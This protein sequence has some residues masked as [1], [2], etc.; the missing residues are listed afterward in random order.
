[1]K[2]KIKIVIAD[3]NVQ[4]AKSITAYLKKQEDMQIIGLA[5][6]GEEA[7]KIIDEKDV[8]VLLLDIMMPFLD[9]VSVLEKLNNTKK[10]SK[11]ICIILSGMNQ[12]KII[13][14]VMELGAEYYIIKPCDCELLAKRI[15]EL[16]N[17]KLDRNNI[18]D[19]NKKQNKYIE[20]SNIKNNEEK[21]KIMATNIINEL[22]VPKNLK[23]YLYIKKAII[24][25]VNDR[26]L[27]NKMTKKIYQEIAY[28]FL[29]TSTSVQRAIYLAIDKAWQRADVE[30]KQKIF[31]YAIS[32]RK[33]K[34][35]NNEFI[36]MIAD[37]II[38]E[39]KLNIK[40]K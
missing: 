5:K 20:L 37:K 33:V 14:R 39:L 29:D 3:D 26:E 8:D 35:K 13:K 2:E 27:L 31:G 15:R 24:M 1:M 22:E 11:P 16:I 4:F 6:N 40:D 9:G 38:L 17:D 12:E 36:S 30:K 25:V 28:K 10:D 34:P 23:G 19:I 21:I 32:K 18:Y 7:L